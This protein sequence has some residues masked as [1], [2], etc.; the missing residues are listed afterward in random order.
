MKLTKNF[1]LSEF[2]CKGGCKMPND[3]F[4]NI[5]LLAI[6]LQAFRDV[7]NEPIT[8]NSSYRCVEYNSL[9]GG[10]KTSQ[11]LLGKAADITIKGY[12]PDEV[13]DKIELLHSE[14]RNRTNGL[15]RYNTFTHVDIRNNYARWDNRI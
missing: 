4:E 15:G 11:H 1:S 8:I 6:H 10:S 12:T 2:E 9:V 13:A 5:K 14:N 3:V 7:F